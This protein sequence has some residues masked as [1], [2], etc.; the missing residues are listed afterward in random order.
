MRKNEM[1]VVGGLYIFASSL[2]RFHTEQMC[3]NGQDG[4]NKKFKERFIIKG[5]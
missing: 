1:V 4:G 2:L 3:H 5:G